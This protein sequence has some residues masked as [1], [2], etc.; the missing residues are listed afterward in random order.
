[1]PIPTEVAI[2]KRDGSFSLYT[3]YASAR[4]DAVDFD[5]IQIQSGFE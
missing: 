1:M 3:S 4:A 2:Y 5:L